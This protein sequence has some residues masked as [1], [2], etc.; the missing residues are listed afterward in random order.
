MAMCVVDKAHYVPFATPPP[1]WGTE[2][3]AFR[4]AEAARTFAE[5]NGTVP[6]DWDGVVAAKLEHVGH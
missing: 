4:D 2:F 6:T 5:V 1:Y 3:A